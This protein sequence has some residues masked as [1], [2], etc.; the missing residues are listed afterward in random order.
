MNILDWMIV[1]VLV[2]SVI[3]AAAQ[4]F[5]FELFSLAGTVLGYL[6][7]AWEYPV[8]A[9]YLMPYVKSNVIAAGAG[10]LLIFVA[11]IILAGIAGRI[12]RWAT[13]SAGL[14]WFDRLLGGTFGFLRGALIVMVLV[15][16]MASFLPS[17]DILA[18]SSLAPYFLVAGRAAIYAGPGELKHKFRDGLKALERNDTKSAPGSHHDESRFY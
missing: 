3:H 16:A 2:I 8:A 1:G 11:V 14:R 12:A 5:V 9:R 15:M 18:K 4:G 13:K 7:A 17:M 10:F 6:L